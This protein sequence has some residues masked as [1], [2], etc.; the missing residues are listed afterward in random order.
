MEVAVA[1]LRAMTDA[2]IPA[3]A[4]LE[5]RAF[6]DPWSP[7]TFA[8]ELALENRAYVVADQSGSIVGYGGVMILDE[9]AHIMTIAVDPGHTRRKI[10]TRLMLALIDLALERG[11]R[12]LTLEVRITNDAALGMYRKL[13]FA[14][15]GLRPNY[16]RDE[17]ALV[18]WA[19]DA[20]ESPF[21]RRLNRLRE[22]VG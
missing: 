13:G 14:S 22:E 7:A 15:V 5:S 9:E 17:D 20:D 3:V 21:R 2:D 8:E 4:I 1:V 19:V 16:Y 12:H 6:S 10:G 18:M 11:A